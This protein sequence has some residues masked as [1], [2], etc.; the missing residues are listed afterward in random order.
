MQ[1]NEH[2]LIRDTYGAKKD[3]ASSWH[4]YSFNFCVV[5]C[6]VIK[7]SQAFFK[8]NL[9]TYVGLIKNEKYCLKT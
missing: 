4:L 6:N 3:I 1:N 5:I 8:T 2:K 9:H 7:T